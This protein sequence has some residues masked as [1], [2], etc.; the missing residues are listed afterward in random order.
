MN[1]NP[2]K[3]DTNCPKTNTKPTE[4]IID[5]TISPKSDTKHLP[6]KTPDSTHIP[7]K[8]NYI[9]KTGRPTKYRR[10]Y[11]QTII[12]YF[13]RDFTYEKE[14]THTN[15]KGMTWSKF[16]VCANPVPLMC[17]FAHHIKTTITTLQNWEKNQPEFLVAVTH[18]QQLQ[19]AH[20]NHV[21]GLGLYNSN[22]AVFMAKNISQWRDKK[23]VEISGTL[24][25]TVFLE[26]MV[27]KAEIAERDERQVLSRLN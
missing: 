10:K 17:E 21:T 18:A 6:L 12:E 23:D 27:D 3:Q 25:S 15:T 4:S 26:A 8:Y 19:L 16:E 22:W 9:F 20:L 1:S 5:T 14:V 13:T 7:K 24:D 2:T 11:C